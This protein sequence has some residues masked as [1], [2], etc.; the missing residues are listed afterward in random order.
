[1]NPVHFRSA[2]EFRKWLEQNHARAPELWIAFYKKAANKPGMSYHE[3]LDEALCFGWI[4]GIIKRIDDE[5][6]MH[7]FTPRRPGSIWSKVN[8][9]H[10]ERLTEAG[11]MHPAGLAA[12]AARQASRTGTYS[13]ESDKPA[14]LPPAFVREFRRNRKAWE[15]FNAQPPS[16]RRLFIHRVMS[17]KRQVTRERWLA[18][19]IAYSAAGRRLD[20]VATQ[21]DRPA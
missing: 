7:R 14:E 17:P 1:M 2:A 4:D 19:L 18:R 11:R 21:P 15:F 10:V 9:R 5:R 8:V 16:Y 12:F 13:F 6:F 3:A 20:P